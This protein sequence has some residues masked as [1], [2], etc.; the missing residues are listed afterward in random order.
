M[1]RIED[2]GHILNVSSANDC[3][4]SPTVAISCKVRLVLHRNGILLQTSS[5]DK[6]EVMKCFLRVADMGCTQSD[7]KVR[8]SFAS[9]FFRFC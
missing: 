4:V 2:K 3:F 6:T 8:A 9:I 1:I 5:S 7:K